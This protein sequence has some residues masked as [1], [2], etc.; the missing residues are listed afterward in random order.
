[1]KLLTALDMNH[2]PIMRLV[3]RFGES[4]LTIPAALAKGPVLTVYLAE[5]LY[6][7]QTAAQVEIAVTAPVALTATFAAT[8]YVAA[9]GGSNENDGLTPETAFADAW[10][11]AQRARLWIAASAFRSLP[12][13]TLFAC[14]SIRVW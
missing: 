13:A 2:T 1:M 3:N 7:V 10:H 14:P 12:E 8:Y 4:L 9:E 11:A 5:G 6:D